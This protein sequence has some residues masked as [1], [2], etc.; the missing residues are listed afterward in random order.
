MAWTW[1]SRV[2][3]AYLAVDWENGT[4]AGALPVT[5]GFFMNF[6]EKFP[7]FQDPNCPVST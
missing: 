1:G 6:M 4:D 7:A 2:T 5:D 3:S